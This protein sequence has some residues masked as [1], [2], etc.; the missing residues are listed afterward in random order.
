MSLDVGVGVSSQVDVHLAGQ[1]AA[2]EAVAHLGGAFP[3]LA[4]AFASIRYADPRLLKGIRSM[5]A[6]CPLVGCTDAGGIGTSG[7]VRRSIVVM[8]LKTRGGGFQIGLGSGVSKDSRAAGRM[9]AESLDQP[10]AA[11][12]RALLVFPEGLGGNGADLIRGLQ[13]Q[14]GSALPIVGGA[15][16]DDFAFQRTF[17]F[18]NDEILTDSVPGVLFCGDIKVGIGVEHGWSPI[19]RLR[20][21]TNASGA[22]IYELDRRPAVAVYEEYLG[23]K[24]EDWSEQPLAHWVM[25]Y[26]LGSLTSGNSEYLVRHALRVGEKGSIVCNAEIPTGSVVH[27][28]IGGSESALEAAKKAAKRAARQVGSQRLKGALVFCSGA[29]QKMFGSEF[30][31]E[32]DVIRDIIGGSGVQLG[33][34]YT[35]GEL[36]PRTLSGERR[37]ER[38]NTF[39]NE[40]VAVMA[41]G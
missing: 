34:F 24:R 9:L 7:P 15:A 3:D 14:L 2:R 8:V 27:L 18:F 26:P 28:M 41:L 11:P 32:I 22:V 13:S 35:Y 31:G 30:S 21:V 36:A 5:T 33:G 17:Q 38:A 12:A 23:V 37:S 1:E 25:T 40:S 20:R 19:G 4:L 6:G 39:H 29:R 10:R 16:A